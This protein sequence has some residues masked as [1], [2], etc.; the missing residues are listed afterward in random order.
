MEEQPCGNVLK[1]N[2]STPLGVLLNSLVLVILGKTF[3][4]GFVFKHESDFKFQGVYSVS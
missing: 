1:I 2:V 3:L 4:C